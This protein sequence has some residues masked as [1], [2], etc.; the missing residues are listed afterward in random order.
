M[1]GPRRGDG[2]EADQEGQ[3]TVLLFWTEDQNALRVCPAGTGRSMASNVI[4]MATTASEKKMSRSTPRDV[5][6]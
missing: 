2:A 3:V 4:A 5:S 6:S 1:I